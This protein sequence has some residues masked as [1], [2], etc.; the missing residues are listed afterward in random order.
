MSITDWNRVYQMLEDEESRF[1]WLNRLDYLITGDTGFINRVLDAYLPELPRWEP[2]IQKKSMQ[3]FLSELPED[4]QIVL[5]GAGLNGRSLL[6]FIQK[7]HRFWGFC[8]STKEKQRS[9]YLGWPVMSPEELLARKDI[10][11][12]VAT[13]NNEAEILGILRHGKYPED[14]IFTIDQQTELICNDEYFGP[15]FMNYADEEIFVDAGCYDLSS[16][17]AL[18]EHC[19]YVKKVYAFEPDQENFKKCLQNKELYHFPQAAIFPYGT[20]SKED[21]L[22]FLARGGE[23][24]RVRA[25]G[26]LSVPVRAIDEVIDPGDC[27]TFIKMDVEGSELESLKGAQK[28]IQ[29]CRPKLAICIYHRPEDMT[30][31][32][33]YIKSLVPEYQLYVRHHS[34]RDTE[35]VLYAVTRRCEG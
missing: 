19:K 7:D 9:G 10:I 3:R 4:K 29:R 21:E 28:T 13:I 1:T 26:D 17:I 30:E 5:F 24:S 31:I 34:N 12:I 32:P 33:L 18:R 16:S 8:S 22:H 27:V 14:L 35:T 25:D 23:S 2:T 20:W 11:V 6:P 15:K